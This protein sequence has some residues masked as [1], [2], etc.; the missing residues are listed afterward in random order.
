MA[1][2]LDDLGDSVD[3]RALDLFGDRVRLVERELARQLEVERH[4]DTIWQ[5]D[6]GQVVNLADARDRHGRLPHPLA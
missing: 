4:V 5:L 3:D 6:H 1:L 2:H